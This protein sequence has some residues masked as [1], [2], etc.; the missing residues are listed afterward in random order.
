MQEVYEIKWNY[1]DLDPEWV[2]RQTM[3]IISF[4]N[5]LSDC[6]KADWKKNGQ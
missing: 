3:N 4:T 5:C 1:I 6:A 2:L